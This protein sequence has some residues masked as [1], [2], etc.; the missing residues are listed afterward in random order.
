MLTKERNLVLME[1]N[2]GFPFSSYKNWRKKQILLDL[3]WDDVEIN[4][5]IPCNSWC[6]LGEILLGGEVNVR[7]GDGTSHNIFLAK[8]LR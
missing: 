6:I 4:K 7:G 3:I 5:R 8:M 1:K 2:L